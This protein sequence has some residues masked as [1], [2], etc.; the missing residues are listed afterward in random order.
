MK[1]DLSSEKESKNYDPS[2]R[3]IKLGS[4][5]GKR[6]KKLGDFGEIL[7]AEVLKENGFN[8]IRNLNDDQN[9]FEFADYYAEKDGQKFLISVKTRNKFEHTG[10]LNS[11]YKLGRNLEK[12]IKH[13]LSQAEFNNCI[14]AWLAI[15]MEKTS[16]DAYFG[17]ISDLAGN[18]GISMSLKACENYHCLAR[19]RDHH[20][21]A[22][23]FLN[24]YKEA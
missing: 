17:L 18:H 23:D 7:A 2:K 5:E 19:E 16:F 11:R 8:K 4:G 20:F 9:N 3:N 1:P 13:V 6:F 10:I 24:S 22:D 12:K 15:A 14:P 21:N